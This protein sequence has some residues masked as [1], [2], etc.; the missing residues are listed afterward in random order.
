M[1][2]MIPHINPETI[3]NRGDRAVYIELRDQLPNSWVVRHH[4]PFCT[5][6]GYLKDKE[7]DFLVLAPKRGI[8]V[9]EV[10]EGAITCRPA[11][12]HWRCSA[13]TGGRFQGGHYQMRDAVE[14][15]HLTN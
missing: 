9:L 13:A 10:K 14:Y 4:L 6:E 5:Y 3:A 1:A 15:I 7:A 8:L 11:P 12:S 2:R